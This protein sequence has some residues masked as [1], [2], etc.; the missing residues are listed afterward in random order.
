MTFVDEA[1]AGARGIPLWLD[2]PARPAPRPALEAD[3][4]VDL[5]VV[6]GGFTGLWTALLAAE[7]DPGRSIAVLEAGTL[8]WAASGRNGG[9]CSSSLTHGLGNGLARWPGELPRLLRLGARTLDEI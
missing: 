3:L 2:N 6:G 7:A 8:G 4:T 1:L 5:A 9:F